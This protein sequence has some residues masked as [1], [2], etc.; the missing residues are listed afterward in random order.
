MMLMPLLMKM[1]IVRM[2]L[3]DE[4]DEIA[5]H[6]DGGLGD[7]GDDHDVA[8]AADGGAGN[9][10]LMMMVMLTTMITMMLL[11]MIRH[12]HYLPRCANLP[13]ALHDSEL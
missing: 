7:G 9:L 5:G 4:R 6:G 3:E 10:L 2:E 12:R 13:V 11:M 8:A 1:I